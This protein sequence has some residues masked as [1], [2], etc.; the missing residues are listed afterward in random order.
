M[1]CPDPGEAP[2]KPRA[3]TAAQK[4]WKG[5][6]HSCWSGV[7]PPGSCVVGQELA[8]VPESTLWGRKGPIRDYPALFQMLLGDHR[9]KEDFS[10]V[11]QHITGVENQI[12]HSRST[13]LA[14]TSQ[15]SCCLLPCRSPAE[16]STTSC[17]E[18]THLGICA[19]C[20]CLLSPSSLLLLFQCAKMLHIQKGNHCWMAAAQPP[21]TP[22]LCRQITRKKW[23]VCL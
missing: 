13:D 6:R 1:S 21:L 3:S 5:K 8:L 7:F 16:T 14:S 20:F 11:I 23:K 4:I 12:F 9:E 22:A 17:Y 18:S 2:C 15:F 10:Q 19:I